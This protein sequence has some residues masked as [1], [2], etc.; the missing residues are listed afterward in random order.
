[1]TRKLS[2]SQVETYDP[3][4]EGCP[5]K[6]AIKY[7][8]K[9]QTP[10]HPSAAL[11]T[12]VHSHLEAW[13][14]DGTPPPLDESLELRDGYYGK[15]K[16]WPGQ[17]MAAAM[18]HFP[19]PR[20]VTVE[21]RFTFTTDLLG[22]GEILWGGAKDAAWANE[23]GV[24]VVADLKT[25]KSFEYQ[26][27]A[28][29]LA[30]DTQANLYAYE[31]MQTHKTDVAI[32][33]WVTV[34][35]RDKVARPVTYTFSR[36][37]VEEQVARI[38]RVGHRIL[39]LYEEQPRP[40]DVEIQTNTCNAY[41]GC[42]YRGTEHCKLAVSDFFSADFD[43]PETSQGGEDMNPNL[44]FGEF[45]RTGPAAAPVLVPPVVPPP[46]VQAA[47]PVVVS[48]AVPPNG[49][50]IVP[51]AVGQALVATGQGEYWVP[52]AP[53]NPAQEWLA[54]AGKPLSVIANAADKP[55]PSHISA[56][57]DFG[58]AVTDG[59]FINSPEAAPYAP[60]S[61]EQMP[62]VAPKPTNT[63][64]PK[65][66]RV[67]V[68]EVV[69]DLTTMDRDALKALAISLGLADK[70]SRH[71]P[72]SLREKIRAA[73][74]VSQH[75]DLSGVVPPVV[76]STHV[77]GSE[78]VV[79]GAPPPV[80]P[81]VVSP[82]EGLRAALHTVDATPP[83]VVVVETPDASTE[84]QALRLSVANAI[85]AHVE[86]LTAPPPAVVESAPMLPAPAAVSQLAQGLHE[87]DIATGRKVLPWIVLD[88]ETTGLRQDEDVILECAA[89]A[90][91]P[92]TLDEVGRFHQLVK[93]PLPAGIDPYVIEMHSKNGLWA[94]LAKLPGKNTPAGRATG[95]SV[96]SGLDDALRTFLVSVGAGAKTK[97]MLAGNSV[98]FDLGFLRN[99][100]P[101]AAALLSH[102]I[103][104]VTSFREVTRAWSGSVL[105]GAEGMTHRAMDDAQASLAQLRNFRAALVKTNADV[106]FASNWER[107]A[108]T[109]ANAGDDRGTIGAGKA[110]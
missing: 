65:A 73:R 11:G 18:K 94:E 10:P 43:T 88:L 8:A 70:S 2:A 53:M 66:P 97:L 105:Q 34:H 67:Q 71:G 99:Q 103:V 48:A 51:P 26:K 37:A 75:V 36:G 23:Q 72:E 6:W 55:P 92:C 76:S 3:D 44:S 13:L 77:D 90:V 5:R 86:G 64:A 100:C 32:G 68:V 1:M 52:G 46:V 54:S 58:G 74:L 27:K 109:A 61:P 108:T 59:G 96:A 78:L 63:S 69:D 15:Y 50:A 35:T 104:D 102:R 16:Y 33:H 62:P 19:A 79:V 30:V 89:I 17:I 20:T 38:E 57:Y 9:V 91:D 56:R 60:A 45:L 24:P 95:G 4:K 93:Q 7:I 21:G 49:V 98:H 110:A 81:V 29:D 82:E 28:E 42:P 25:T 22:E 31:A 101:G 40:Q 83:A 47:P 39:K 85:N 107:G 80:V 87:R 106:E 14:R 12:R 84:L 41:G